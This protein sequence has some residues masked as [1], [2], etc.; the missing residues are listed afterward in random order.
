MVD[1]LHTKFQNDAS[2]GIAYIYCNF[3]QQH[4]QKPED[5]IA[6]LLKQ[7]LQERSSMPDSVKTL[8]NQHKGKRTRPS[9]DEVSRT[10]QSVITTYSMAYIAVDALDECQLSDGCRS[11]FLSKIFNLQSNTKAKF[12]ATSRPILD[13]E[14]EFKGCLS[15][16]I[17]ASDEDVGR[18]LDSHMS[19]LPMVILRR[20]ELQEEIKTEIIK[21]VEGM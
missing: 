5:L 9:L 17:L 20:L 16:E 11:R 18:Y 15:H 7:F 3:R 12:L 4:D 14:K 13:I 8:Y 19:Q 10:L 2:I 21:A 1:F 6:S